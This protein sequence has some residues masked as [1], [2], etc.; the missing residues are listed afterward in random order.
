MRATLAA[1]RIAAILL[2]VLGGVAAALLVLPW[3]SQRS[4]AALLRLWACAA[5]RCCGVRL[6][7]AN[8]VVGKGQDA[9]GLAGFG[10]L[11]LANHI[12][13]L[14][15]FAIGAVIPVRFVAKAEIRQWPLI[16][17]MATQAGTLYIER[18]RRHAVASMNHRVRDLLKSGETVAVFAEGTTTDGTRVLPFHSNLVAPALD[19]GCR[20]QPVAVRYT[21][22]GLPSTA[23]AFDGDTTLVES[24]WHTLKA[25]ELQVELAF[26]PPVRTAG[27]KTRH[28]IA[29]EAQLAIAAH[30]GLPT[31]P[32]R[33]AH[34]GC[35]DRQPDDPGS[36]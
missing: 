23:T 16:G 15:V 31:A 20:I 17:W 34:G 3:Q 21:E 19:A 5:L 6:R 7:V 28:V 13:W 33:A 32:P 35:A 8:T 24:L 12:S 18:R 26:L 2:L 9:A 36:R 27:G 14:D 22:R 1:A 29:A 30:L 11:V 25:R 10:R 4:R